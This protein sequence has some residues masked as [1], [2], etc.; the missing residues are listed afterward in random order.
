MNRRTSIIPLLWAMLFDHT[1]LNITFPVLTLLFF[2]TQSHL[3][4]ADT[5]YAERSL[6]YGLCV[7]LPHIVNIIAAPILS[8]LSDEFGRKRILLL[9]TFGAFLFALTAAL[10]IMW[11]MLSVLFLGRFIQG[12]FSRTNPIAQAVIGDISTKQNKVL[13]MGYLQLTI[14]IGAFL[15]PLIGGYFANRFLFNQLNFSLPYLIAALLG[16][17]S[18]LLTWIFF[19]ETLKVPSKAKHPT[20]KYSWLEFKRVLN[21]PQVISISV[22]LLLVQIS[23]SIYYQ[24][25]PPI[26]KTMLGFDAHQLGFFVGLIAFWLA[27]AT[28]FGIRIL[29][30]FLTFSQMLLVSLY[31]VLIGLTLNILFCSLHL[32][33]HWTTLIWLAAIPT[34]MGD[35]IAYSCITALYSNVVAEGEQG[36]VMAI[37]ITIVAIVW[38][39][40][41]LLGGLMM[42]IYS[43]LPLIIAPIG[44]MLALAFVHS[45]N[46]KLHTAF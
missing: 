33:G 37:C 31:L 23:W 30:R 18:C 26:L 21:Y 40:T 44:V 10:G 1:S 6:W 28:G 36:K 2:D 7:A 3:F 8:V 20:A 19:D 38:S 43:M 24:F 15:G 22:I 9:G 34:A 46:S 42:S 45:K 12:L 5:S 25:T 41:G 29:G 32:T 16:A 17:I 13:N 35:V 4:P 11:G 39:L 14:S 27:L